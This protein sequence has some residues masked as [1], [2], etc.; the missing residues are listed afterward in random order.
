MAEQI[1]PRTGTFCWTELMTRGVEKAKK[2][3]S[4][5]IGWKIAAR[6]LVDAVSLYTSKSK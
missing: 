3:Y 1:L 4:A 6:A 2:F 5:L